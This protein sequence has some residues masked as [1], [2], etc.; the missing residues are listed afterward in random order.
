MISLGPTTAILNIEPLPQRLE[1]FG[2][3]VREI[4]GHDM[5][6]IVETLESVPFEAGKPSAIV[7]RTIKGRGVSFMENVPKW[8][9]RGPTAEETR[10]AFAELAGALRS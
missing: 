3:A 10:V 4:D 1:A 5:G 9:L 8:H 6:Q 2:W 7:A